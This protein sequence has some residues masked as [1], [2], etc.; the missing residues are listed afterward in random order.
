VNPLDQLVDMRGKTPRPIVDVIDAVALARKVDRFVVVN[1]VLLR[2][3][4]EVA[5][6]A[7]VVQNVTRG[8]PRLMDSD[9]HQPDSAKE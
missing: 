9:W 1:E 4:R 2:Y 8:N 7:M 5:H 6:Q 3:A